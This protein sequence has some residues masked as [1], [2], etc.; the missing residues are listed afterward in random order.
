[1]PFF[2]HDGLNFHYLDKGRGTP[3]V[4]QH[5]LGGDVSQPFGIFAPP[6]GFRLLGFDCGLMGRRSRLENRKNSTGMLC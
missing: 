1:M 3:F 4:F 2:T 5:G 6:P